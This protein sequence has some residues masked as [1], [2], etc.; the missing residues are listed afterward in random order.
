MAIELMGSYF[1]IVGWCLIGGSLA[2]MS[3]RLRS[4]KEKAEEAEVEREEGRR[5]S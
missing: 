4:V 2:M 3:Y 1:T 5:S